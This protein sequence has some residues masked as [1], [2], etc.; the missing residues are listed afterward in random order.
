RRVVRIDREAKVV[1]DQHGSEFSYST[2]VLATGSRPRVPQIEGIE[3]PGVFV[4]RSIR[5]AERLMARQ[6][7]SRVTVVIGGGLLGLEAARAMRRFNTQVHVVEHESRLMF[8][9]LDDAA[10]SML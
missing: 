3:M 8:H 2:L 10:A 5:D 9:Q 6:I 4:F 1:Y 7:G